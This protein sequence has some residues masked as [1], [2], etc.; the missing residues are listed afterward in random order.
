MDHLR[1]LKEFEMEVAGVVA[2][3]VSEHREV[4]PLVGL[5]IEKGDVRPL[6]RAVDGL[7]Q[8]QLACL[9]YSIGLLNGAHAGKTAVKLATVAALRKN[10]G[11]DR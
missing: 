8:E 2:G 3:I 10:G 6:Y 1:A 9:F 4:L 5:A 7:E 11:E